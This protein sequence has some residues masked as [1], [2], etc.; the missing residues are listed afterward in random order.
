LH[1]ISAAVLKPVV[2]RF[3][4]EGRPLKFGMVFPVSTHNYE[5]RYWLAAGGIHPGF[6][7]PD[8]V[9]GTT[10]ADIQLSVTPPPQMPAT[11]EAGT[12]EGYSVGEPWN[13]AAVKKKIGVPLISDHDIWPRNPEK[14]LGMTRAFGETYP[15]TITAL[16]RALIKAQQW[17]DA[18]KGANRPEAVQILARSNYVGA[19]ADVIAASMTGRFTYA[20]GDVRP[21]PEFN[22]F[23]GS[24]A[25][26][27][28]ASDAVWQLTQM[29]RWGQIADDHP[30]AWYLET[31][32]TVYR[33]DLYLAAA[34]ALVAEGVIPAES[35]PETDGF[36]GVQTGFID[37][38]AYDG[39]APNAYLAKFAI[40]LKPGQRVAASGVSPA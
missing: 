22:I 1:P 12:I 6:Y 16:I 31:A 7:L 15:A 8:D 39:R 25:G 2:E 14:V 38:V 4:S 26:Y 10:G 23:F 13:Q 32:Q 18:D 17:L 21:A 34:R 24:F 35:V 30:D 36:K 11:L 33:A 28:F 5:L 19:D 37:G 27:P 9:A 29:R 40:G 3:R 20:P